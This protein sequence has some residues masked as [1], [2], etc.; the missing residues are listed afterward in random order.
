MKRRFHH[1]IEK[2]WSWYFGGNRPDKLQT[3]W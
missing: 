3:H 2:I 1:F